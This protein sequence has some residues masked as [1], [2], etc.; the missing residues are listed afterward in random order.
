MAIYV[1]ANLLLDKV[2]TEKAARRVRPWLFIGPLVLIMGLLVVVPTL[3]TLYLAFRDAEGQAFVGFE[4]LLW[5]ISSDDSIVVLRNN[6]LW[7]ALVTAV[8]MSLG[9]AVAVTADHSRYPRLVR[10]IVFM[11]MAIS[12][13]GASVVWQISYAFKP[14][15]IDQIGVLNQLLV[16]FGGQPQAFLI[17]EPWNN[18]FLIWIM[19]WLWTGFATVVFAAAL[20]TVPDELTEASVLDG[21]TRTQRFWRVVVPYIRTTI[22]LVFVATVVTV[23]KV[24]DIIRVS[25]NGQFKTN[26]IANEMIEQAFRLRNLGRASSLALLLL[27]LII[28]F[29]IINA[30]EFKKQQEA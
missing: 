11:P 13:V 22:V 8:T 7:V 15:G 20:R 23:L 24:F 28:P 26:V 10:S 30:R 14:A 1:G 5:A 3:R 18:L 16:M 19:I 17:N 29:M 2:A 12:A 6:A 27:L 21:A 25:T 9:M 4:N